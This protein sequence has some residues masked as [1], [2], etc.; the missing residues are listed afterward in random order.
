MRG[1]TCS[2]CK[3]KDLTGTLACY[4][5]AVCKAGLPNSK[6]HFPDPPPHVP[7]SLAA[8]FLHCTACSL[9]VLPES[10]GFMT[11]GSS[12][13]LEKG[14][15]LSCS[16]ASSEREG[17]ICLIRREWRVSKGNRGRGIFRR[18]NLRV[19]GSCNLFLLNYQTTNYFTA[20][21]TDGY[22]AAQHQ[23]KTEWMFWNMGQILRNRKINTHHRDGK[24]IQQS[25]GPEVWLSDLWSHSL[26]ESYY[27]PATCHPDTRE[28]SEQRV[29]M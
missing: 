28:M 18:I 13:G 10:W 27:P 6:H 24:L 4:P 23:N 3:V 26:Q 16:N 7:P 21:L 15:T 9:A 12:G 25:L 22:L 2:S 17:E 1:N 20:I 8:S 14:S 11:S 19:Q 29:D 5:K